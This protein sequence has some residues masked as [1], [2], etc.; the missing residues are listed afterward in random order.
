MET[1]RHAVWEVNI[2]GP[3]LNT[4][5]REA[6]TPPI[7]VSHTVT[8]ALT[9]SNFGFVPLDFLQIHLNTSLNKSARDR[10][11][12]CFDPQCA[13]IPAQHYT[14]LPLYTPLI[15]VSHTV[16]PTLT[17]SNLRFFPLDFFNIY[18]IDFGLRQIHLHLLLVL[19][20]SPPSPLKQL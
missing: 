19:Q 1:G 10:P 18:A 4:G 13:R 5:L 14:I 11:P 16:T 20:P 17:R 6:P 15:T 9:C 2:T 8:P 3:L 12:R 7:M